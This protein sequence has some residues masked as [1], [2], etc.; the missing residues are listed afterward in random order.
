[1][2]GQVT[3]LFTRYFAPGRFPL[4]RKYLLRSFFVADRKQR[5]ERGAFLNSV[6]SEYDENKTEASIIE[7]LEVLPTAYSAAKAM[8]ESLISQ[9]N[10]CY[11]SQSSQVTDSWVT[12]DPN[13][14]NK[15]GLS[16]SPTESWKVD[17]VLQYSL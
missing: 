2:F 16:N 10:E 9:A 15:D 4:S 5:R 3:H 12:V 14:N 8:E 13:G 7:H 6:I 17:L 1:M 11:I